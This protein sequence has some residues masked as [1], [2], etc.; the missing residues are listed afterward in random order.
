MIILG[1]RGEKEHGALDR[2]FGTVSSFVS[3]HAAC[4]VLII[5]SN[6]KGTQ[7]INRVVYGLE[8]PKVEEK[9]VRQVA[10]LA[11][12]IEADLHFVHIVQEE[13][14]ID[15]S[16]LSNVYEGIFSTL[17][18]G[19]NFHLVTIVGED[20]ILEGL[21]DYVSDN[22]GDMLVLV[23]RERTWWQRILSP[24]R[25]RALALRSHLPLLIMHA[26]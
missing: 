24:S 6:S 4:P 3:L 20:N 22:K 10:D 2:L 18:T 21:E 8:F 17:H 16:D 13:E 5:P 12:K 25:S 9:S 11:Y 7:A 19:Q 23:T 26:E 1:A 14:I 15:D